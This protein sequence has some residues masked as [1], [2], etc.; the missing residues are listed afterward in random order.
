MIRK[1]SPVVLTR[2]ALCLVFD[3]NEVQ[4]RA[5]LGRQTSNWAS[6][7]VRSMRRDTL[8]SARHAIGSCPGTTGSPIVLIPALASTDASASTG[9]GTWLM[10]L[11]AKHVGDDLER[12]NRYAGCVRCVGYVG[13]FTCVRYVRFET[14]ETSEKMCTRYIRYVR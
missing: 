9:G 2:K 8:V 3:F 4:F 13:Y 1:Y 12:D 7:S 6:S 10:A 14:F 11:S 5:R